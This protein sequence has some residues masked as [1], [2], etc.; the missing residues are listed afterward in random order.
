MCRSG[1][2]LALVKGV[3]RVAFV[4]AVGLAS[5]AL[6]LTVMAKIDAGSVDNKLSDNAAQVLMAL[7]TGVIG[8]LGGYI[9][10]R[11][12]GKDDD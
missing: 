11:H 6:G 7:L 2:R 3:D 9:G 4:L 10:S 12:R 1:E 5:S 8:L